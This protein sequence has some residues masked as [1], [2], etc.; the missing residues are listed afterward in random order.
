MTNVQPQ[1][2]AALP[3]DT[4]P[5]EL[6]ALNLADY[7][8]VLFD[9][10][11]TLLDSSVAIR[12]VYGVWCE[13]H[14]LELEAVLQAFLGSRV[15]DHLPRI[16][17]HL[18]AE[19]EV[20]YLTAQESVIATGV[21]EI[22]GASAFIRLLEARAVPWAI[23]TSSYRAMAELRLGAAGLPIPQHLITA[24]L[25][26]TGK[27]DPEHFIRAAQALGVEPARCLAFEDS[28]N[29]ARSA[30]AAGCD[31]VVVGEEIRDQH[32]RIRARLT[33]Y[34][35]LLVQLEGAGHGG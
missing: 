1:S 17:P 24:E 34:R 8:A 33:D 2:A 22:A 7:D 16:A 19:K 13:R 4:P 14:G 11:G 23:A 31:L 35:G 21:V 12:E 15:I 3:P 20:A 26:K 32:P 30:L 28:P 27:P 5:P 10:D 6:A 18:D 29:G 25:I 9:M